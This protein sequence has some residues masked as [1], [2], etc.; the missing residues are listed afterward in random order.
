MEQPELKIS[1]IYKNTGLFA[2]Y[3][4][5]EKLPSE[6]VW[7][8]TLANEKTKEV[9]EQIKSL[10]EIKKTLLPS[11][12]E[13]QTENEFI[14]PALDLLGFSYIVQTPTRA[15]GRSLTPDYALF[16][17]ENIKDKAYSEVRENNYSSALA[18]ADA[19]YWERPLDKKLRDSRDTLT[20]QNPT[21]QIASY[22]IATKVKWAILTNGRFW[23]LY[24]REYSQTM[25]EY[26]EVDLVK[27]LES[28]N[29]EDFLYFYLFF[30]KEAFQV[31]PAESLL[32]QMVRESIEYGARLQEDLKKEIFEKIFIYFAKGF[33]DW[34]KSNGVTETETPET[35][36]EIFDNTLILLYRLLFI[37]Y[38]ESRDLLPVKERSGYYTKS[39]AKVKK[40]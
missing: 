16:A 27:I 11:F 36:K 17:D 1:S 24:S 20:N 33:T 3:F 9:F 7:Q 22:L 32:D 39:L 40:R 10:Y 23:R 6:R 26:F 38:A 35:L 34:R 25:G 30:R 5:S 2:D 15:L 12:N 8:S 13:A 18:I 19:K 37:L 28:N 31:V 29:L 21:F 4:L 14:R